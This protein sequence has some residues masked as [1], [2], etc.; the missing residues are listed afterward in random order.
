MVLDSAV[1]RRDADAKRPGMHSSSIDE[2]A[3]TGEPFPI[4]KKEGDDVVSGAV[5]LSSP[6]KVRA[7]RE[8][9]KGF[10]QVMAKEIEASMKVKP[11]VHRTAERIVQFFISG[12]VVYAIGVLVV[13]GVR[14]GDFSEGLVRMA[15]V[16]A[17][18]PPSTAARSLPFRIVLSAPT[19]S[20]P[21][22][23]DE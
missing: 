1:P 17:V 2:S 4:F 8:R 9:N 10:L 14:T 18:A 22:W 11:R 12:V 5:N 6:L 23:V 3:L 15:A 16:V 7:D 21:G 19:R 20:G 13:T